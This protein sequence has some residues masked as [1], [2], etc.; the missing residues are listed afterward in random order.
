MWEIPQPGRVDLLTVETA[1]KGG[2]DSTSDR[3]IRNKIQ[4]QTKGRSD[5]QSLCTASAY[6]AGDDR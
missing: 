2:R 5:A 3:M 4:S 1:T 6:P